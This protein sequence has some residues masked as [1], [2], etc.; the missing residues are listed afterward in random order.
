MVLGVLRQ[1]CC[2]DCSIRVQARHKVRT[3]TLL[4]GQLLLLRGAVKGH[5]A[6][7]GLTSCSIQTW[8][9]EEARR[10]L[11]A[12]GILQDPDTKPRD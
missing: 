11:E 5:G 4:H 3:N 2:G 6:Y 1:L 7:A 12:E 9:L 8:A 10:R